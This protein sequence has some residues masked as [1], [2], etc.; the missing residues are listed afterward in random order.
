MITEASALSNTAVS[1]PANIAVIK[2]M[3]KISTAD[4]TPANSSLSWTLNE[5]KTF[6]RITLKM[7]LSSDQWASLKGRELIDLRMSQKSIDRFLL[8]FQNLKKQF[9]V[10]GCFLVESANNFPSDCGLA[11]SA[12]SFA[13]LTKAAVQIFAELG[14][15]E[16]KKVSLKDLAELSRKGSGSSCRSFFG[17]WAR[18]DAQGVSPLEYNIRCLLHQV[19]V[20]ESG[21]KSV[22]SS[23][24]HK[25][26]ITSPYFQGRPDRAERRMQELLT[27]FQA[28][29]EIKQNW[30]RAYQII[31]D[32]FMDMHQLFETCQQPFTYMTDGTHQT[33]AYLQEIWQSG[34]GPWVTMDAGA[35]IH[36][37]YRDDQIELFERINSDM[38]KKFQVFSGLKAGLQ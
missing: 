15:E 37:L 9:G 38:N 36:L 27:V 23:E 19:I 8:H 14:Y 10:S 6:V 7:D 2:Y 1:A 28:G 21:K 11:S 22:S 18:W 16:A 5:L 17:P 35:N 13:A 30:Q 25:L 4:N 12:S 32:E 3:G 26:V 24:A 33:L 20:I 29:V 34:D 31:W